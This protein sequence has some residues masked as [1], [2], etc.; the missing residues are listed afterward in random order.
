LGLVEL[1]RYN[2]AIAC[3][4]RCL[5]LTS[6]TE[7]ISG[8]LYKEGGTLSDLGDYY[9]ATECYDRALKINQEYISNNSKVWYNKGNALNRLGKYKDAII[10]YD[11]ALQVNPNDHDVYN[12]KGL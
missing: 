3:Y 9:A 12:N 8:V 4:N 7:F 11:L 10:Q 2:E 1:G 6:N 5:N